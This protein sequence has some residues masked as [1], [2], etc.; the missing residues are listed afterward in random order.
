MAEE[1]N[2]WNIV[3]E[4]LEDLVLGMFNKFKL[5]LSHIDYEGT[6]NLSRGLL[7]ETNDAVRLADHMCEH[8]GPETAVEVAIC[9][10]EGINKR[11]TAAKLKQ[12]RQQALGPGTSAEDYRQK[13][14]DH[15]VR[16][17]HTF[18]EVNARLGENMTLS[19][20]YTKL[21]MVMNPLGRSEQEHEVLGLRGRHA[22]V[23]R[24]DTHFAVTVETLFRPDERGQTPQIIVIVGSAG[25][26]KTV[27]A[28]K[29]MLDWARGAIYAQFDYA[30]YINCREINLSY[31]VDMLSPVD[32]I[33][34]CCP[35]GKAPPEAILASPEKLLFIIDG[36]DELRFPC[37]Q[38]KN[39]LCSDCGERKPVEIILSSLF[40]KTLFSQSSLLITTRPTA[41]QSLGRC[42]KEERY[43]EI[44][45]FSDAE[46]DE[47]FHK[48]FR[49]EDKAKKAIT[50]VKRNDT[51]FAMCLV[52]IM[53][54]TICTVLEQELTEGKD[55]AQTSRTTT[56]L[57]M[58]YL[59]SLLK[60]GS[61]HL[62]QDM[63]KFLSR[64]CCMAADGIWKRKILFHEKEIE[65]YGLNHPVLL[66]LF[67]NE[68]VIRN[69]MKCVTVYSFIHLSFQEFFAALFYALE[70]NKETGELGM[71]GKDIN[72][73]LKQYSKYDTNWILVVRFL[74]GLLNEETSEYLVERTGCKISPRVKKDVLKWIKIGQ[75]ATSCSGRA[76][77]NL[78]VFH[79]LFE[80]QEET[81]VSNALEHFT[82]ILLK[83][84]IL[85]QYDQ[86]ILSF[87][88]KQW[89]GLD[90]FCLEWC[91]VALEDHENEFV[92]GPPDRSHQ[93]APQAEESTS[94]PVSLLC[95]ALGNP[96]SKLKTV[97]LWCC[98]LTSSICGDLA[99]VLGISQ[100]LRELDLAY[101]DLGDL[102]LQ[103]LCEGLKHPSCQLQTLRLVKCQL[104]STICGDLA[105][106]LS[107]SQS[108]RELNL[109]G[110]E[111]GDPG[112]QLLCEGLKHPSCQ[113]QTLRL[114][115]CIK[116]S[117]CYGDLAAVL[118]TNQSLRELDLIDDL[119]DPG[120][121]LLCE[122]LKY[123]SCQLQKLWLR[124]CQLD[125]ACCGE[126]AAVLS[127][128]QSL[129]ELDV[130]GNELE[131]A[132][133]RLLCEGL[134]HP[135]CQLQT[136]RVF[137]GE[138]TSACGGDLA[139]MLAINQN[140]RELDLGENE[141]GDPGVQL[142]CE[143]LKHPSCQLQM[144]R[145]CHCQLTSTICG[146]LAAVLS[147]SQSLRELDLADNE[148][149]DPGVQL[150][151]EGLKHPSC[152]LQTLR[153]C[154]CQ[155]TSTICGDLAAVLSTSQSLRELDL[156]DN[157]LG[158]PG[159]QLLCEGLKHPSCQLQMLR[160]CHC[161]LTSTI[162]GD[163]AAVL[164]TSQSLRELDLADNELG[165]P[166]V[167]LLCEGLKHP[168][169]QLQMLRLWNCM[170]TSA[171]CGYLAMV[172]STNL[173][174]RDLDLSFNNLE[175][176]GVQLLCEKLKH[177][178]WQLQTLRWIRS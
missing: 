101:N 15:V 75:G 142:L 22:E 162:C 123:P 146:D 125:S 176:S 145:L 90:S 175:D 56:E 61:D 24:E 131:D 31:Q 62:K 148:L 164:S 85:S 157:E 28:R 46:K 29:I 26:G 173:S 67:L 132:G 168:S 20:R 177:P 109:E 80:I 107:T 137:R 113:L 37:D 139:T 93:H 111:L 59:S 155:L 117:T 95:Q 8:Y 11:D 96:R 87:C 36:F 121:Q 68:S 23:V 2:S 51:L 158:D 83:D 169:C 120:L 174:V 71:P 161:Q 153:L 45:G 114:L 13:Y 32:L 143:G 141:L 122:G 73:V 3:L 6:P 1:M 49:D 81:F 167:Q 38:P 130:Q 166:G 65:A 149:G 74:F 156:A 99:A 136:L 112:V 163:L 115:N 110:S 66:S 82:G 35:C 40:Q 86:M 69:H 17:F 178:D 154:H 92:P 170:L 119:R 159:V 129:R 108:L 55:L 4:A 138:L 152:Q 58:L 12:K 60:C 79:C 70:D 104:T 10:L 21:V 5:K 128:S 43:V 116:S 50:F 100:S 47:Y 103:L 77:N 48:F 76:I 98:R 7:E 124:W 9:V 127:T 147:T 150:L 102:G 63:K 72:K 30:F 33:S 89:T 84:C 78:N 91:S 14:R 16:E 53:C 151:C 41:L 135:S 144:L 126:L 64:L 160:L 94:P 42:L 134:K 97:R 39:K 106:V 133:L 34:A 52:P 172:L 118:C 27:T 140:L 19:S 165:D 44:L 171:C 54:W 88:V 18:E 57:Y 105:A 25:I